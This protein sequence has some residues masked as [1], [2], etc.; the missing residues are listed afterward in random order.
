MST[1]KTASLMAAC[2]LVPLL[3]APAFAQ[4]VPLDIQRQRVNFSDLDISKPADAA[5]MAQR[6]DAAV[7]EVCERPFFIIGSRLPQRP[8]DRTVDA[9][10]AE[11]MED[12]LA[13]LDRPLVSHAYAQLNGRRDG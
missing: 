9:C 8:S 3:A 6:L 2:L 7:R 13:Q 4:E 12:A 10:A 5:I 11:A 1:S